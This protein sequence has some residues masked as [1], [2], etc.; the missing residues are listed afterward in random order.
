M[1]HPLRF[2][3][4][5]LGVLVLAAGC[6][7]KLEFISTA[8][9]QSP[10]R[11]NDAVIVSYPDELMD[12]KYRVKTGGFFDTHVYIIDVLEAY[13]NET[14]SRMKSFFTRGVTVTTHSVLQ[15]LYKSEPD[16]IDLDLPG[17]GEEATAE[18]KKADR[19]LE[20]IL[21]EMARIEQGEKVRNEEGKKRKLPDLTEEALTQ[22]SIEMLEQ[23]KPGYA[24]VFG[25]AQLG[26]I[27][28]RATVSFRAQ[29]IDWRTKNVLL[30]RRYKGQS[31][32]FE[33]FQNKTSNK[34][35]LIELIKE[36]FSGTMTQMMD[37][38]AIT[39]GE[40]TRIP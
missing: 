26:F 36:A 30:D 5:L 7:S 25:D 14:A 10:Y 9:Y 16:D 38:I 21:D 13:N 27:E 39:T 12:R 20:A 8:P 34:N 40:K 3:L 33:P 15:Q 24:L 23:R 28:R 1:K 2:C 37:D 4:F 17:E 29:L 31:R 35:K 32:R 11:V 18:E 22:S 6:R 19:D